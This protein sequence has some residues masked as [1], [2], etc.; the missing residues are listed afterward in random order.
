[1]GIEL[2]IAEASGRSRQ[3]F[4]VDLMLMR[5]GRWLRLMGQDVANPDGGRDQEIRDKAKKELR[6]VITRDRSLWQSCL[7]A[8]QPCILIISSR[9]QEQLL[10]MA[11]AG[12]PLRLDPDRCTLCNSTLE[13]LAGGEREQ[14]QCRIC[15]K[16][17][18]RGSHWKMMERMLGEVSSR[19]RECPYNK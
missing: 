13:K 15:G 1:M 18:W 3:R 19:G 12:L 9:I 6:T 17:Y 14:W 5:L 2:S 7:K 11:G 16:L 4:I 10:E 8:N